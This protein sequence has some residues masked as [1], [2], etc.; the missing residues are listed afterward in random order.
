MSVHGFLKTST[1]DY[2][3]LLSSVLFMSGCNFDCAYCY[4]GEL[5]DQFDLNR[6][7]FDQSKSL[8]QNIQEC[9]NRSERIIEEFLLHLEERKNMIQG[10]VITGGEP[11]IRD[12]FDIIVQLLKRIKDMGYKIKIDTNGS[13]NDNLKKL[14]ETGYLDYVAMDIKGPFYKYFYIVHPERIFISSNEIGNNINISKSIDIIMSSGI[15]YEF[16]TT[17]VKGIHEQMDFLEMGAVIQGAKNY[18][19]QNYSTNDNIGST[20]GYKSFTREEL[21][22]F[23]DTISPFVEHVEIRGLK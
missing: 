2:P 10:V 13:Y 3:G 11:L 5:K 6:K 9:D 1:V 7:E 17:C 8:K 22:V 4:N 15:D 20:L 16:R 19:L 21:E 12:N 14:I 23:K 18:Y